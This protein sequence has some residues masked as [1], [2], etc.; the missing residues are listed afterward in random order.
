MSDGFEKILKD[1]GETA[2][3]LLLKRKIPL[4]ILAFDENGNT[5]LEA[6]PG[7]KPQFVQTALCRVVVGQF[8][9]LALEKNTT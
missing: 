2:I 3:G 5:V 1:V 6:L 7:Y 9:P 4:A 8:D